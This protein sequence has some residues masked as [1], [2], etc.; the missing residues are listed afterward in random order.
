M[1]LKRKW[2]NLFISL[3]LYIF[4]SELRN[5]LLTKKTYKIMTLTIDY[6]RGSFIKYNVLYFNNL[7][8]MPNFK[9]IHSKR[10]LGT[11][12]IKRRANFAFGGYLKEH[13]ISVSDYYDRTEKQYDNTIIHEMIHLYISQNDI[14]DN[15]SHGRH[16]KAECARI[17]KYGW[18]LSRCTD[19]SGWKLSEY[20]QKKQAIKKAT[21][22][23]NVIIYKETAGSQFIFRVSKP[24]V[25]RY[26]NHLR[27]NCKL[28]CKHFI[29]SDSVFESLPNCTKRIRGRRL[30]NND[31]YNVYTK[32]MI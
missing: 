28:E 30:R 12:S 1:K 2:D 5:K 16:F 17:N 10:H 19:T 29:S 23:Y 32:Y 3:F 8:K 22:S 26:M 13:T 11:L 4:V 7:L 15:G 25:E 9:I 31:E 24:N 20:A 14:I 18:E 21:A 6:I 27:N